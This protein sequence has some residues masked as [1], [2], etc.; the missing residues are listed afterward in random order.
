MTGAAV[1]GERVIVEIGELVVAGATANL[2]AVHPTVDE[3]IARA[4]IGDTAEDEDVL[5][6]PGATKGETEEAVIADVVDVTVGVDLDV[7]TGATVGRAID[8]QVVRTAP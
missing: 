7:V 1:E 5:V 6:M 2:V 8:T 3:V 4:A